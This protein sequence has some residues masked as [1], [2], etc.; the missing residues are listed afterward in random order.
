MLG[1]M[2][3][4][5]CTPSSQIKITNEIVRQIGTEWSGLPKKSQLKATFENKA[6]E[7]KQRYLRELATFL[8][9]EPYLEFLKG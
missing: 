2:A 7:D 9:A 3:F 5:A 1:A 6:E 4:N 8:K